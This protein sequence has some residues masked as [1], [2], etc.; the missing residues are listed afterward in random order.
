MQHI[1]IGN[2]LMQGLNVVYSNPFLGHTIENSM[3][4]ISSWT[5]I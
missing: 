3:E 2:V 5:D 1:S 4:E